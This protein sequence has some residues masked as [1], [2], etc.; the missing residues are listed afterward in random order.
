MKVLLSGAAVAA[1][2]LGVCATG[3]EAQTY[4]RLVVFGDSLSDNGNLYMATSGTQPASP[5]YW[6]GR[7]SS[8]RGFTEQLGFNA[9]NFMGPVTGSINMAFG[10]ART[11]AQAMPP[12]MKVQLGQYLSRGGKFGADDLVTVLGGANNIFQ[13]LPAAGGSTN[14]TSSIATVSNAAAADISGL[15]GSVAGAGAGTIAVI[16]SGARLRLRWR[17]MPSPRSTRRC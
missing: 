3:A 10:G 13:G 12:G 7:F 8:G 15:V 1:L 17:T 6:Q 14:P 11:D 4:N 9:A 2:A 16:S 5:P